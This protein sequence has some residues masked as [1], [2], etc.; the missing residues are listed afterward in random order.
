MD[1]KINITRI[2][3]IIEIMNPMMTPMM[4]VI[5]VEEKATGR[6]IVGLKNIDDHG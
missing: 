4:N 5:T 6:Q 1:L 3:E 2:K